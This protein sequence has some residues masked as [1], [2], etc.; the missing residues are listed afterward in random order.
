MSTTTDNAITERLVL[1]GELTVRTIAPVHAKLSALL[2]RARRLELE[3]GAAG[4]IDVSFIQLALAARRSAAAAGKQVV[5]ARPA[6]G[7]LREV[8]IR[9]GFVSPIAG[10]ASAAETWWS[11]KAEAGR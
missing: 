1:D 4:P 10:H 6:S 8:L 3:L 7:P 5:W 11:T 2:E 9:G